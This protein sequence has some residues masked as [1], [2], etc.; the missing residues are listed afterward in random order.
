V[1]AHGQCPPELIRAWVVHSESFEEVKELLAGG[2][3]F[4]HVV[5]EDVQAG[6]NLGV[7]GPRIHDGLK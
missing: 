5:K 4:P 7:L 1:E 2:V 3:I 6:F